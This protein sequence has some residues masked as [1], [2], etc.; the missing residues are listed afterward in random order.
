MN[1]LR[2][3]KIAVV[4][5]SY[6]VIRHILGV[7]ATIGPEVSRIFV[8]DDKYPDNSENFVRTNCRTLA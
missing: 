4:I 5:P 1:N 2:S 8:V 3:T 6:R 7:I